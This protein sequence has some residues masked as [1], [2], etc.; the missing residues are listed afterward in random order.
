MGDGGL[1]VAQIGGNRDQPG[2]V[3]QGP[4]RFSLAAAQFEGDDAAE[5]GLLPLRQFVLR[6]RRQSG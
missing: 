5:A 4:G 6:M 1:G 3:D 2:G